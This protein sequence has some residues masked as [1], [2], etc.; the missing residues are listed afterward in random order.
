M[1]KSEN[2]SLVSQVDL[3]QAAWLLC[4]SSL[5][6]KLGVNSSQTVFVMIKWGKA[7]K[8]L[9]QCLARCEH[10]LSV[11]CQQQ[12]HHHRLH[13]QLHQF[14]SPENVTKE[15]KQGPFNFSRQHEPEGSFFG[16]SS[17]S[18]QS[19]PNSVSTQHGRQL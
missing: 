2:V 18:P 10:L 4:L 8:H 6:Y 14:S 9:H 5:I 15:R 17:N 13:H 7:P 12:H 16:A 3:G 19:M 1:R 11:L